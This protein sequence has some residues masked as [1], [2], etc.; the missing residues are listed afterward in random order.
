VRLLLDE[1]YPRRLA[2]DLRSAGHDVVAVVEFPE[3]TGRPDR[4][5]A[6]WARDAGRMVVTENVADFAALDVADHGG[7]LFVHPRRWRRSRSAL[8]RLT[9][10]L[11]T[12]LGR[13]AAA[14]PSVEWL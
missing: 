6:A 9:R 12:W 13:R 14:P 2:E 4:E 5:V 3:L 1:M 10:A 7:L 8:P 11:E